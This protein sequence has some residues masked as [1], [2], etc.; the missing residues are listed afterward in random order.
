[1]SESIL[2]SFGFG[3]SLFPSGELLGGRAVTLSPSDP[4]YMLQYPLYGRCSVYLD[5]IV[6]K[7]SDRVVSSLIRNCI[8]RASLAKRQ[9]DK[10]VSMKKVC[11]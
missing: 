1:M 2:Y 6:L 8:P 7:F 5:D 4:Q 9:Q 3:S 11:F 10:N